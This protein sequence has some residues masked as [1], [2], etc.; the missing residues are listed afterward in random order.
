LRFNISQ[1][2]AR[3]NYLEAEEVEMASYICQK[4]LGESSFWLEECPS[5]GER[6]SL[7]DQRTAQKNRQ[8]DAPIY[9]S[10]PPPRSEFFQEFFFKLGFALIFIGLLVFVGFTPRGQ[11]MNPLG[12]AWLGA[13]ILIGIGICVLAFDR[14]LNR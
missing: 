10:D 2:I 4:C 9:D 3:R 5:C 1:A 14:Y 8:A 13:A 12:G 6:L 11:K 7:Q